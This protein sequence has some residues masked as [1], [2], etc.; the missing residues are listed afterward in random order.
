MNVGAPAAVCGTLPFRLD[1]LAVVMRRLLFNF[2]TFAVAL[3]SSLAALGS[4]DLL[5]QKHLEDDALRDV[6]STP[7][8][9]LIMRHATAPGTGDPD[10]FQIE[11]CATQRNLS[12]AGRRQAQRTGEMLRALG[13]RNSGVFSSRWCRCLETARLLEL[14]PVVPMESLNSFFRAWDREKAQ[15]AQLRADIAAMDL[16]N[17]AVLV[18]HQVVISGLAGTPTRSGEIIVMRRETPDKLTVVGAVAPRASNE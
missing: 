13:I 16:T 9:F 6:L 11:D 2:A 4:G 3:L 12:D 14:G 1:R 8:H 5:A 18:T 10:N 17:P 15:I 7:G